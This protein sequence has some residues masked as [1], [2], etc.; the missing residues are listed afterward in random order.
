M[1]PE[2]RRSL[3]P[4]VEGRSRA[5][6]GWGGVRPAVAVRVRGGAAAVR[7]ASASAQ[8]K[9]AQ[10]R[11]TRFVC[12]RT[13]R[14]RRARA[15]RGRLLDP[16][17]RRYGAVRRGYVEQR[18]RARRG[19]SRLWLQFSC[20][21]AR[22]G[23]SSCGCSSSI[24]TERGEGVRGYSYDSSVVPAHAESVRGR[25][26]VPVTYPDTPRSSDPNHYFAR[27][28]PAT[29]GRRYA[30]EAHIAVSRTPDADV[31]DR[32]RRVV[33]LSRRGPLCAQ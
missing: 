3:P 14:A 8:A 23:R 9:R 26:S 10:A 33:P 25:S 4:T 20:H 30:P 15:S 5:P 18:P 2:A 11:Q 17:P 19:L 6:R 12:R 29:Y 24:V 21:R 27:P 32:V 16:Y 7:V 31:G 13:E 22:R 28:A 1:R